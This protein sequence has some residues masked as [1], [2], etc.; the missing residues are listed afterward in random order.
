MKF[1]FAFDEGRGSKDKYLLGGKGAN[2]AEMTGLGFPVPPGFT[3]STEACKEFMNGHNWPQGLHDEMEQQLKKLEA[4]TGKGFGDPANPLLLSVRSGAAFSMPGMMDTVLNLG[5]NNETAEGLAKLTGN[6]RF[7]FD[8]YRRFITMFSDIVLDISKEKFEFLLH[9]AKEAKGVKLDTELET[10]DLKELVTKFKQLVKDEC[11]SDFPDDPKTQLE[12]AI[13]AVFSSWDNPRARTYRKTYKISDD[14]GTGVNVQSMVFG[15][16]GDDSATGVAF[17]RDPSTGELGAFGEYLVNAQGEDVVAGIRTPK[18]LSELGNDMPETHKELLDLMQKLED[19]YKDMQD[20]EFTI[21]RGKLYM[22]QTRTGK[23]TALAAIKIAVDMEQEGRI[24]KRTAVL[25]IDPDQLDQLLHPR[26]D[27]KASVKVL[28]KGIPASPGAARGEIVLDADKAEEL[29]S[30]G[31]DVILVRKETNPD[32]IH[33][34]IAAKGVL[35]SY[36]GKTSH[37]AVVARGMGKPCVTGCEAVGIELEARKIWI[38]GQEFLEGQVITIDGTSGNI[39]EGKAPLIDPEVSPDLHTILAWCDE[40]RTLGVRANA[41]TPEDVSKA[42]EFGAKGIGLCRTEHMFFGEDRLPFVQKMILAETPEE[43]QKHID[44]LLPVQRGDFEQILDIMDGLPV[45]I[46][47]LD[48]PLHEFL[49]SLTELTVEV[50]LMKA[51]NE[52]GQALGEKMHLLKKVE[53]ETEANPMLGLRGCR[54]G[55]VYPEI[56]KMQVRAIMEAALNLKAKGKNPIVE[57]MIPLVAQYNEL[58]VTRQDALETI[59]KVFSERGDTVEYRIGTMIEIPR[60]AITADQIAEYADFFSFGTNDLTQTTFGFS[61]DDAEGKF[62]PAYLEQKIL[63]DNP[64]EILDVEG[65]G[66]LIKTAVGLA[67]GKKD[68]MKFGICGEHGGEPSSIK[69]CHNAGLNYVSCS[70]FRV[71]LARLA[72]AQAALGEAEAV[73]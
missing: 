17:T 53:A 28:A 72:A 19:H 67:N 58:R 70:P 29:G 40:F 49:P 64:F 33:G 38:N 61:R 6:E 37:A 65:V 4:G 46:R 24:D 54:L 42:F 66:S 25:R 23:R 9:E 13:T 39:I 18:A 47:L 11:G 57:I 36:G 1:I 71:P 27:P 7:V 62:L 10:S 5:L 45:T 44:H 48:P 51:R 63:K 31:T 56:Y 34:V 55:I 60:A 2:L 3:I 12:K 8:A 69:F 41:E 22:L 52:N 32:D 50:E 59:E 35:T 43:R 30:N 21:E 68:N 26:I 16:L 20:I 14:L 73:K 15:N